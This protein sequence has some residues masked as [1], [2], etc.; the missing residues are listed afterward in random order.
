MIDSKDAMKKTL[1]AA[2]LLISISMGSYGAACQNR[3]QPSQQQID[4]TSRAGHGYFDLINQELV[5]RNGWRGYLDPLTDE[6]IPYCNG[7]ITKADEARNNAYAKAYVNGLVS[8][9]PARC[10]QI[11]AA[12]RQCA[13]AA[14]YEACIKRLVGVDS[15]WCN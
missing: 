4:A 13:S 3:N 11:R 9:A 6:F 14:N 12:R 15:A 2:S 8:N 10:A 5:I 7:K 1:L